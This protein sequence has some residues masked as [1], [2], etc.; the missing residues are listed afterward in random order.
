MQ[1]RAS[2]SK[3]CRA[4]HY[5]YL[6]K[7]MFKKK[8][9]GWKEFYRTNEREFWRNFLRDPPPQATLRLENGNRPPAGYTAFQDPE[10]P[11]Q[12]VFK[13]SLFEQMQVSV[14]NEKERDLYREPLHFL[15][16]FQLKEDLRVGQTI[17][18]LF[19][20]LGPERGGDGVTV[21]SAKKANPDE[22]R[23]HH[24]FGN[25]GNVRL[26]CA[27]PQTFESAG[28]FGSDAGSEGSLFL[29][30]TVPETYG[31][32]IVVDGEER[33]YKTM[34]GG[35]LVPGT[36][37]P[38]SAVDVWNPREKNVDMVPE[39]MDRVPE[40]MNDEPHCAPG[41]YISY[42]SEE[43]FLPYAL[44][45]GTKAKWLTPFFD[46]LGRYKQ[47]ATPAWK[48][49]FGG[50][51]FANLEVSCEHDGVL[52]AT[53]TVATQQREIP[54]QYSGTSHELVIPEPLMPR[55][56][57]QLESDPFTA[58]D[59]QG[60]APKTFEIVFTKYNAEPTFLVEQI[61]VENDAFRGSAYGAVTANY[62][63]R[64][65]N[66][67]FRTF[68]HV[69]FTPEHRSYVDNKDPKYI[70]YISPSGINGIFFKEF[71]ANDRG[72]QFAMNPRTPAARAKSAFDHPG[73]RKMW[74]F[75]RRVLGTALH[76]VSYLSC[77]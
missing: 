37:M 25:S 54:Q 11:G 67:V 60:S 57:F 75:Q 28:G 34:D 49:R 33:P 45:V 61:Q 24:T 4:G 74:M 58:A 70:K 3:Q 53:F 71:D 10:S 77:C 9:P 26:R 15:T 42:S 68:D 22:Y 62:I 14:Y 72:M 35:E 20:G 36:P 16:V 46:A 69:Y 51:E 59:R 50:A 2:G 44:K 23:E 30:G 63:D 18:L 55:T 56:T 32:T 8:P 43:Y 6:V 41:E 52:R 7:G 39:P 48:Y 66:I 31:Q 21:F 12:P 17:D 29:E 1:G 47:Y 65:Q 13:A 38:L 40:V 76:K 64:A 5:K 19:T 27:E 73:D